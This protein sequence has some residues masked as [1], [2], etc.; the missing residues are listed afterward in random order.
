MEASRRA[1]KEQVAFYGSTPGYRGVL[2]LH[3]WGD[4]GVELNQLSRKGEWVTM[5]GL[6]SDEVLEAFAVV[7]APDELA[8]A[9]VARYGGLLDRV[10]FDLPPG[11]DPDLWQQAL[12]TLHAAS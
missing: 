5:G 12:A 8:P 11:T 1:A 6:V 9:L 10:G 4:L 3:G 7:A 2:E